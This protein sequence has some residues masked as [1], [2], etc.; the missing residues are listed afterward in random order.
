MP[1]QSANGTAYTPPLVENITRLLAAGYMLNQ[2]YGSTT[3]GDTKNGGGK[4]SQARKLL[5]D[6]QSQTLVL[7][8]TAGAQLAR[9]LQVGGWPD[10]TTAEVGTDGVN[11]EP[12][13]M[14]MSK[15]F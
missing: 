4:I 14:T 5:D 3:E 9:S 12:F 1:L 8:D 2:D 11:G 13:Q 7:L 6:I 10:S 15:I